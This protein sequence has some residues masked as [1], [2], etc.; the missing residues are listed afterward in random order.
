M[1]RLYYDRFGEAGE[2]T[3]MPPGLYNLDKIK[4]WG[5]SRNWCPYYVPDPQGHQPSGYTIVGYGDDGGDGS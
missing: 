1:R 2:G 4:K 3:S 5:K